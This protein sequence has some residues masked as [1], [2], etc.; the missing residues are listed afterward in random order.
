LPQSFLGPDI[1]QSAKQARVRNVEFGTCDDGLGSIREPGFKQYR[2]PRSFQHRQP[3]IRCGRCGADVAR[4]IR[5]VQK[6]RGSQST[7]TQKFLE[8]PQTADI[9][10]GAHIA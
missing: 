2:L 3:L 8:I 6:I 1:Q 4:Q 5:L 9:G 10:Q 7:S